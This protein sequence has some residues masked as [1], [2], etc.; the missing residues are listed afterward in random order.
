MSE[1]VPI[2]I[3]LCN[4][5]YKIRVAPEHE[6]TVRRITKEIGEKITEFK[7]NFPGRDEQDYMAMTLIDHLTSAQ[8]PAPTAAVDDTKIMKQLEALNQLLDS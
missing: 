8:A 3:K 1:Q 4:R 2:M 5:S 7:S 6:E